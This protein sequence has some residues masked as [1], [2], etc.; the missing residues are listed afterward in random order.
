M[1][2]DIMDLNFP[3]ERFGSDSKEYMPAAYV[4]GSINTAPQEAADIVAKG[5]NH[6]VLAHQGTP[7]PAAEEQ[8]AVKQKLL[9]MPQKTSKLAMMDD[10]ATINDIHSAYI[11]G[12]VPTAV[13]ESNDIMD[14]NF[15][16]ERFGSDSKEYMPAAYVRGSTNTA[17]AEAEA[18]Q[19]AVKQKL[20]QLHAFNKALQSHK[21]SVHQ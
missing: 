21:A 19:D 11:H 20:L 6:G 12:S 15:P 3:D 2:N 9:Q 16:D 7:A 17:P 18:A 14:L 13:G 5:A 8:D 4:R 1:G 10:I